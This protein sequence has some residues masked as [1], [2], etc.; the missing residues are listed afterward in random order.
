M[1]DRVTGDQTDY[2]GRTSAYHA[3]PTTNC[4]GCP[5][6]VFVVLR[7]SC[8]S[9]SPLV[10]LCLFSRTAVLFCLPHLRGGMTT[11]SLFILFFHMFLYPFR[12]S[13]CQRI[14]IA[15][16]MSY[17]SYPVRR[18]VIPLSTLRTTLICSIF[19]SWFYDHR[20]CISLGGR[21]GTDTGRAGCRRVERTV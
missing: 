13:L 15:S 1:T 14:W 10:V 7:F 11:L 16:C 6:D 12:S 19:V 9:L 2:V 3:T 18:H 20:A 8:P 5:E 4:C 21:T 17:L